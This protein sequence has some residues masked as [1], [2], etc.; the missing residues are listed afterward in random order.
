MIERVGRH[1]GDVDI[2]ELTARQAIDQSAAVVDP[3]AVG[4]ARRAADRDRAHGDG[5][6][7]AY[8]DQ[9]QPHP[10]ANGVFEHGIKISLPADR[11]AADAD[12][13]IARHDLLDRRRAER[14]GLAHD[15]PA[16]AF[17]RIP[18]EAQTEIADAVGGERAG[19]AGRAVD[20]GVRGVQFADHQPDDPAQFVGRARAGD[21]RLILR[22]QC[23]PIMAV[24]P[25]IEEFAV[26]D[27]PRLIEHDLL[28]G[29][30]IDVHFGS[31]GDRLGLGGV[32]RGRDDATAVEIEE[33]LAVAGQREITLRAVALGEL[34]RDRGFVGEFIKIVAVEVRAALFLG[35][36]D[37]RLAVAADDRRIGVDPEREDRRAVAQ[38]RPHDRDRRDLRR[39][40]R[41]NGTLFGGGR[42]RLGSGRRGRFGR[43]TG[44]I[45]GRARLLAGLEQI[46]E[47]VFLELRHLG[48]EID[49]HDPRIL[50]ALR[51]VEQDVFAVGRPGD[52]TH[53]PVA[54]EADRP[55]CAACCGHD[56]DV[57]EGARVEH[58]EGDILAVGRPDRARAVALVGRDGAGEDDPVG[59]GGARTTKR[60]D[61]EFAIVEHI[62]GGLAVGG[63][64][65][66][67]G[68]ATLCQHRIA[69]A[70]HIIFDQAMI[71]PAF[72][73]DERAAAV[74][75]P[76]DFALRARGGGD[77]LAGA[78]VLGGG[79]EHLAMADDGHLLSVRRKRKTLE[80]AERLVP[81]R[82]GA[83]G[84]AQGDRH[85]GSLAGRGIE[86]PYAEIAFEHDSRAIR[87]H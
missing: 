53:L 35:A 43:G 46:V 22:A 47:L 44:R 17:I 12:D 48:Q 28:F 71:E 74:G 2:A 59:S 67:G 39:S 73:N 68:N 61:V 52:A 30:E 36:E 33:C 69:P 3:L 34:L 66:G 26:E 16:P 9:A 81:F 76:G 37:E 4:E 85:G 86:A 62:G 55:R 60:D 82:G 78:A 50:A 63:V 77:A 41:C 13:A 70:R 58:G 75:R 8:A 21:E 42:Q 83:G 72:G 56:V 32:E 27:A 54:E 45:W 10:A 15:Q 87:G 24:E 31:D 57:H 25:R 64:G 5:A 40:W 20:A 23:L 6:G 7:P 84:T 11:D 80:A 51:G 19:A 18:I 38:A 14:D 49:P 29:C 79:G 65:R 1:V